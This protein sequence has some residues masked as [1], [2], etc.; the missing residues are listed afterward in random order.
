MLQDNYSF[1]Q[2]GRANGL[3][4]SYWQLQ[5]S[6]EPSRNMR[7]CYLHTKNYINGSTDPLYITLS[8]ISTKSF[9]KS[10][11][12]CVCVYVYTHIHTYTYLLKDHPLQQGHWLSLQKT[13]LCVIKFRKH[14]NKPGSILG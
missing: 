4:K 14:G 7:L 5:F 2:M 6:K 3:K 9:R 11:S 10:S 12:I 13:V 1:H 8:N